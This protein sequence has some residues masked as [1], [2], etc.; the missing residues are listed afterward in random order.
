MATLNAT[1]P[2]AKREV[3]SREGK[4]DIF[5][6][7]D[8]LAE[9]RGPAKVFICEAKWATSN[10]VVQEAVDPQ[11]FGYLTVHDT[12]AVLLLLFRTQTFDGPKRGRLAALRRVTGFIDTKEGSS[13]WPIYKYETD[14]RRVDLCVASVHIPPKRSKTT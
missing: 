13:G 10:K 1:L 11:L 2:G 4:S 14:E 6:Q 12:A 9:G 5:I 8:S 3:Y 7:A